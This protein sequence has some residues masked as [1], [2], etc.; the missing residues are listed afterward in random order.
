MNTGF[1][2]V[3]HYTRSTM[4]I[5]AWMLVP[6]LISVVSD[7]ET[8]VVNH[9]AVI[10]TRNGVILPDRCVTIKGARI[11]KV[12]PARKVFSHKN[13]RV[14]DGTGKFLI[15]GL[16]D[17]HVHIFNNG[18]Q[19]PPNLWYLPFFVA[20]GVTGI[21]E[22]WTNPDQIAQIN[23]WRRDV[24]ANTLIAPRIGSAGTLVDGTHDIW[25]S[26]PLVRNEAE[27]RAFVRMEKSAGL[28]FVKVYTT[29]S[30]DAYFAIADESR[31]QGIS[32]AGHIPIYVGAEEASAAGQRSVEHLFNMTES[33]SSRDA[34]WLRTEK[35]TPEQRR[36]VLDT[37]DEQKCQSLMAT[38]AKN[39][40][41][42]VPTLVIKRVLAS[43]DPEQF[44]PPEEMKFIPAAE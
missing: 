7:A 8:L 34:E 9:V 33:C 36:A 29:L 43:A 6:I 19:R 38:M 23:A 42:Q 1:D 35:M 31:K 16:W 41:W 15:P 12:E 26:A 14:V 30:R 2:V 11:L 13:F 28:D 37:Y 22:M 20:T 4:R 39:S 17:M 24:A 18:S 5:W 27:A 3:F 40:T 21:R 32:F 44:A 25:P 10:D